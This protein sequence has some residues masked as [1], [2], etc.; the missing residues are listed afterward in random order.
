M[1]LTPNVVGGSVVASRV[2]G[3]AVVVISA[4]QTDER[5]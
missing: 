2:V 4:K 3:G 1:V 5:R